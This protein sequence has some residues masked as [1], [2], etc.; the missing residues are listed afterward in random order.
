M[1]TSPLR[2]A[3]LG[4]ESTGKSTL[5]AT[6]AAHYRTVWVPEYLR[7]FVEEKQRTPQESEQFLIAS[8]QL[9]RE[10]DS[11]R[12]AN[13]L[14]FCDTTPLMTAIYSQF[15]FGSIDTALEN[16][17]RAHRYDYTIV[18]EPS[19]PWI[20]D[21]LQRESDTVRQAVHKLLLTTLAAEA[22]SFLLVSGAV[23]QRV[24]QVTKYLSEEK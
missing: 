8:T 6:L 9:T 13:T 23:E 16:L 14:L 20:A 24:Q 4:A 15:Y 12:E 22:I 5:A 1:N 18:T 3:L 2:V 19:T 11:A 17:V 10:E 7:E 21:G